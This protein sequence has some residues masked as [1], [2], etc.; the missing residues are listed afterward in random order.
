MEFQKISYE[1]KEG[2]AEIGLGLGSKKSLSVLDEETL[3]ELHSA[4][5]DIKKKEEDLKGLLFFSHNSH[6]F[7]AGVDI[8]LISQ[9]KTESEAADGSE[10]GQSLFNQIEDLSFPTVACVHGP[11]LGGGLELALACKSIIASDSL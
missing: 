9:C 1:E 8:G 7:S 5:E 3:K 2:V 6:C 11:C 10:K 4:I